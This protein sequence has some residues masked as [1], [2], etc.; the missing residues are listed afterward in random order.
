MSRLYKVISNISVFSVITTSCFCFHYKSY[1]CFD[2]VHIINTIGKST[3]YYITVI[4]DQNFLYYMVIHLL[5][6]KK[7]TLSIFVIL[8]LSTFI[9]YYFQ[10]NLHTV[11][12]T[13]GSTKD[14]LMLFD[15][16]DMFDA[17]AAKN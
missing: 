10:N 13:T 7:S 5:L 11:S 9:A 2:Y 14:Q 16:K 15:I 3:A 17:R 8:V 6:N 12:A 4:N 1:F